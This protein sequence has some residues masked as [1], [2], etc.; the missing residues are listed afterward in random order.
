MTT[1]TPPPANPYPVG[2]WRHD[3]YRVWEA[4]AL[5]FNGAD[6]GWWPW[7]ISNPNNEPPQFNG[8]EI[9]YRARP[10]FVLPPED[11]DP[12][13]PATWREHVKVCNIPTDESGKVLSNHSSDRP[14]EQNDA[15]QDPWK[16]CPGCGCTFRG[17]SCPNAICPYPQGWYH[18]RRQPE[19]P[20]EKR[21]AALERRLDDLSRQL[22]SVGS[23]TC[24]PIGAEADKADGD[25][26]A[27]LALRNINLPW[28]SFSIVCRA[29]EPTADAYALRKDS[30]EV[31][32][33]AIRAGKIP[34]IGDHLFSSR[35][36]VP[37]LQAKVAELEKERDA[38]IRSAN[39]HGEQYARI[40]KERDQEKARADAAE[41]ERNRSQ[42]RQDLHKSF[43]ARDELQR[44]RDQLRA[45]LEDAREKWRVSC[46]N[47]EP[48]IIEKQK[49]EAEA[50]WNASLVEAARRDASRLAMRLEAVLR[51]AGTTGGG[52]GEAHQVYHEALG[53]LTDYMK[54]RG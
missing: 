17:T 20:L 53:V 34:G 15:Q 8:K 49:L 29:G 27:I 38:S 48:V 11:N 42:L 45:E 47:L 3:M 25:E 50:R 19:S 14:A 16:H 2:D 51:Y 54:A 12:A 18:E 10:G 21:V 6:G 35:V 23:A 52:T 46:A 4:G 30:A 13:D 43:N 24:P 5:E 33:A 9:D 39:Y 31:V 37:Q 32:L 41:K 44:E 7:K 36:L 26:A 22:V 28:G 40:C 1:P